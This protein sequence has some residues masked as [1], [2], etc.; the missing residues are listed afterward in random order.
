MANSKPV[1]IEQCPVLLPK[2]NLNIFNAMKQSI[3]NSKYDLL[4]NKKEQK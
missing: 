1:K 4:K 3:K 2:E